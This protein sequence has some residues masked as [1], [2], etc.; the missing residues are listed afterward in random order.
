M[1]HE[2][3]EYHNYVLQGMAVYGGD[4]AQALVWCKNHF[5]KLSNSQRNAI[6]KLSAK[7]RNQVIH[8]LT[9]G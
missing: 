2:Q 8:E 9:M 7:E 1:T 4:M 3:I 6:N 5:N